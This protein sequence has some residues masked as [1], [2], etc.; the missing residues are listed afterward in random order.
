MADL[1]GESDASIDDGAEIIV[2]KEGIESDIEL[3][4]HIL[5]H[6]MLWTQTLGILM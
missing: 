4:L 6:K 1:L 3:K 2:P 5:G